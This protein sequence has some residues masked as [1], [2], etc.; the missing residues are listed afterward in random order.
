VSHFIYDYADCHCAELCYAECRY[1]KCR[2]P[3]ER[4]N[5]PD[6]TLRVL[7]QPQDLIKLAPNVLVPWGIIEDSLVLFDEMA[8]HQLFYSC[9]I[10][11]CFFL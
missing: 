8:W 3:E 11:K 5:K 2:G 6:L 10:L 9:H 7:I 4:H 1:A